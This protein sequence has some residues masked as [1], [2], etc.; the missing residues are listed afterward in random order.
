LIIVLII[1]ILSVPA[2]Q[3]YIAKKV[4]TK[5]NDEF[6][7][8]IYISRLGL[9]WRGEVDIREVYIEDHH[10]DTLIYAKALKTNL[11]SLK[12]LTEGDLDFGFI[13]LNKGKFYLKTYKREESD[14]VSIFADKFNS[15]APSSGNVFELKANNI[16]LIDSNVKISDENLESPEIFSLSKISIDSHNFSIVGPN[17]KT[18]IEQLT[19][20]AQR[21]FEI[22]NLTGKFSYSLTSLE[23]KQIKLRTSGSRI[24]GDII[25]NYKEGEISD[26]VNKVNLDVHF[27]EAKISTNDLNAFYNEF[28]INQNIIIDGDL[29]G[30]L[31]NLTFS[32]GQ[33]KSGLNKVTGN[34]NFIDLLS[35]E[36]DF[37]IYA[38]N[39]AISTNYVSLKRLMPKVLGDVLPKEI[40]YLGRIEFNGNT[41]ITKT[42]LTTSSTLISSLGAAKIN[43]N[44]HN[45]NDEEKATYIGD[46][47]FK[48]FDLGSLANTESL[49]T[50]TSKLNI[51]GVGFTQKSLDAKVIGEINSFIFENYNYKNITL[52]G[53]FKHPLFDGELII[54]DPNVKLKFN[55]LVDV[56]KE[57]NRFDF[58]ADVEYAELNKLNLMKRDSISI[59]AGKIDMEMNGNDLNNTFGFISFKETFYQNEN[60]DFY[61]DDFVITS[62]K[63]KLK[64]IIDINSPDIMTGYI[65]GEFLIEDIP[66]LFINGV[67]SVYANFK[68]KEIT[69]NQ[70]ID[71]DFE[72]Y[73]KLI[74]IFVPELQFGE[75]TRLKGSV[76]S[77]ESK[78][79]FDF[80]SPEIVVFNNYL[81]K[82]KFK[83]DNFNPLYNAYISVDTLDNGFYNLKDFSFINKTINDT[84]YISTNF[85]GGENKDVFDLSLY[86]TID[87][88]GN[89][90][91][92]VKKSEINYN[93]N[94]W[95]LNEK[96][97]KNNK[98]IFDNSF[99]KVK[100]DSIV[101]NNNQEYIRFAGSTSD[102]SYKNLKMHFGN[103][104][105]GKLMPKVDSLDLNGNLNGDLSILQK[106]G[107]Y[108]PSSKLTI[109]NIDVNET[110]MGDM[111]IDIVGN[112]EL[113]RYDLKTT[114][115][116][117]NVKSINSVGYIDASSDQTQIQLSVDLNE[118]NLKAISPFGGSVITNIRGL[119]SGIGKISGNLKSPNIMGNFNMKNSGL[120]VPYLNIDFD[121]DDSTNLIITKEKLEIV[122][123]SITDTKYLT[124]GILTGNATHS[125]FGHWKLD[126]NI[127]TNNLLVLDTPPDENQL[128]YGTAFISGN[129]AIHGPINELIIDVNAATEAN[130]VFKI[131]LS[132][133]ESIGDNSFIKFLSPKEKEAK[134]RGETIITDDLKG[135]ALNFE[136]DINKNAE[137]E[138]VIDQSTK[139]ALRGRGAGTLLIEINTLGK[140]NMWGDFIVYEGIY[141]FRYG[142]IIRKEIEVEKGGTITWEGGASNADLNLKAIYKTKANPSAL[143]DDP[144]INR[145][146]PVEVFIDL[147][148][149]ITQPELLFDI[150]FPD[151][152]STVRSEL[153]Y[154]LQTKEE[155]EKQAL[156][157]LTTGSFISDTAGQSAISGTVTDGINAILAQILTDD[158]AIINI[159]PYYD[160]GIDTKE[161]ETQDEFGVQFSSQISERIVVNGKVGI[162]VGKINDS[163]VAGDVD[164]Q[165][166]VNEDGSLRIN[167]FNRQAELQFIGE[168]QTFE[169]GA[170]IS[171]QVDFDTI[172]ELMNKLF[173][174]EVELETDDKEFIPD[175]NMPVNFKTRTSSNN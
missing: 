90:V 151:V 134:L 116:N 98:I 73:N 144:T 12:N 80:D 72:I 49:G 21:G 92:G 158:D 7:T 57:L 50:I 93:G 170:G 10:K 154:K 52:S 14:N 169:Q 172:K 8:S 42:T 166:L 65:S 53:N 79:K 129:A 19:L 77:N 173:G 70:Y 145:K 111:V 105:I 157:L 39:H 152:S 87:P 67:G 13:E 51:E 106:R 61:F 89:S 159:A 33:I 68:P 142:K 137:I 5:L 45:L 76:Y 115:T 171:Y 15:D 74:E 108:Y 139:A 117:N 127:D 147:T 3:T 75:N 4:T 6:G 11:L 17:V 148:D 23:L 133:T 126:L 78:M 110:K 112:N 138:I 131:P 160:M 109:D 24:H 83:L 25:M 60:E 113:T 121:L 174:V 88:K 28:G 2:V 32:N 16:K 54:D 22:K 141:D 62:K 26:F 150:G 149:N 1:I 162:P 30:T 123:T 48:N 56:S 96:N 94:I 102:S 29:D 86:H 20:I 100:F 146:I 167:F 114:L 164:V 82:V 47:E 81:G 135:L 156:F 59:F 40:S 165:W 155:R 18:D 153:E 38:S 119:V 34:F 36:N 55:G 44:I 104:D 101:L 95:Y 118:F 97:D 168:D 128:Y 66:D 143:L 130:T 103:V 136:L 27:N 122:K 161:I 132:E 107:V 120:S 175:D 43:A 140:F 99:K 71:F 46:I 163:R 31:N 41:T 58:K 63:E 64:R 69:E 124:K 37:A 125:N 85:T 35:K 84:L 91:V 9:N